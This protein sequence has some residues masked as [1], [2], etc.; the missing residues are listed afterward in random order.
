[1]NSY[2]EETYLEAEAD[3]KNGNFVEA[4]RKYESILLEEP[5]NGPTLNSLG[6]LSKTQ[7]E[8]FSKAEA[9]YK[10][11]I[12]S[13][14]KYPHSYLNY[15]TLLTEMERFEELEEHLQACFNISTIE[16]S[17]VFMKLGLMDELKLNF[18]GAII[19]N[20][21]AIL[22]AISDEKISDYQQNIV[23]CKNK[24]ELSKNHLKWIN[25]LKK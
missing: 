25:Q 11:S 9:Y 21:K 4:F 18:K 2:L 15:A 22:V 10:A 3:I 24:I 7:I 13:D 20:E 14:S 12:A 6:W 17:W 23:R 16:K 19:N 5:T 8:D 1:M